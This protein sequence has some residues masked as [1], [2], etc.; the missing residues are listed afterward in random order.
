MAISNNPKISCRLDVGQLYNNTAIQQKEQDNMPCKIPNSEFR[1]P[2]SKTGLII[3]NKPPDWT[4]HDVVA[5][6]R[7]MLKT[8][9]IG[10]GGTLD[11]MATGV[12][13]IFIGR[14]TRAVEFFEN[15]DKEY[16]AGIQF[17]I[18]TDTQDITGT[19]LSTNNKK[20]TEEELKAVIP[21][22]LHAQKQIP[23]MYSAVKIGGKKL[24]ELARK[25]KEI[26]RPPRD[27]FISSIEICDRWGR[28]CFVTAPSPSVNCHFHLKIN[29]SK[30]TYIR[31]LCHDIG[32]TLGC[33]AVMAELCRTKAGMFTLEMAKTLEDVAKA[34][35]KNELDKI[36]TPTDKLFENYP[37]LKLNETNTKKIKN[38]A[39][40]QVKNTKEGKH[41]IYSKTG[42]FLALGEVKEEKLR[43]IKTF[44]E[45][46]EERGER[47]VE[48]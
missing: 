43:T 16:I 38:G 7:G 14:A 47:R 27:I 6:L 1:I 25:G 5:K 40:C 29:C 36:I 45:L 3:I 44:F 2:N 35:E 42:E 12:L 26:N 30:G 28:S 39:I 23:P 48:S 19:T 13:P 17:G 11:P 8:K 10:H 18:K 24:Y 33:G 21:N 9:R 31:T 37:E 4:S 15:T 32:Q 46:R 34:V 20:V 41:R 22:F